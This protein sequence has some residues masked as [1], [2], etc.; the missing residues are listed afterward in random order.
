MVQ[1]CTLVLLFLFSSQ[2]EVRAQYGKRVRDVTELFTP[3]PSAEAIV[4]PPGRPDNEREWCSM[5]YPRCI[6]LG[7][8]DGCWCE[9]YRLA[10]DMKQI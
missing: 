4:Q 10:V 3:T 5:L 1:F 7:N 8:Y 6:W 2:Y 9:E